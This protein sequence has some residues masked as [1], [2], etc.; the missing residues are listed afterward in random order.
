MPADFWGD[1]QGG[2]PEIDWVSLRMKTFDFELVGGF[3]GGLPGRTADFWGDCQG[4]LPEM[5]CVSLHVKTHYFELV[6]GFLWGLPGRTG[7][8]E[9]VS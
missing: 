2:L 4:G 9:F 1:C 5:G 3:L 6:G 8:D 7:R